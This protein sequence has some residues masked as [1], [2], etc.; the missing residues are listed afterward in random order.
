M[1]DV[2]KGGLLDLE[3]ELTC[4]V[5]LIYYAAYEALGFEYR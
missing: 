3:K 4:S 1:A 2:P 5:S